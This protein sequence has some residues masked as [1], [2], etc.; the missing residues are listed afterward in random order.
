MTTRYVSIREAAV[1]DAQVLAEIL[2]ETNW[3][4]FQGRV[5]DSCF[6]F[7]AAESA[8]NWRRTLA[9]GGLDETEF[10]LVAENEAGVVVGYVMAGN[11]TDNP[12]YPRELRVLLIRPSYQ[13]QG[14]GRLLM[15]CVAERLAAQGVSAF[16]L[17][18]HAD[19]PNR[20]FYE[21]LDGR[22]L[23]TR[24]HDWDGYESVLNLFGFQI[25]PAGRLA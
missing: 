17:G 16:L 2:I 15:N 18:V 7:T 10:I 13:R 11:E 6:T 5:P 19:N 9:P 14:Y 4:T 24:P 23:G 22:F 3:D 21:H 8:A 1:S 12:D 25:A 20:V